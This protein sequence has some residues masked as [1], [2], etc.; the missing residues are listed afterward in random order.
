M[1]VCQHG[2]GVLNFRG[3]CI[4]PDGNFYVA[5]YADGANRILRYNGTT[6][7]LSG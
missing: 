4:R 6:G 7:P 2:D 3:H 5:D 1:E